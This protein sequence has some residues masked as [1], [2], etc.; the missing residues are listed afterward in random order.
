MFEGLRNLF[1]GSANGRGVLSRSGRDRASK[2]VAKS[3][4]H[5]VLVQDRAGLTP[6]EMASFKKEMVSVIEKYFVIDEGGFDISYKREVETTTLV[7]NSPVIVRRQ[8]APG[9]RVGARHQV[10]TAARDASKKEKLRREGMTAEGAVENTAD[11]I[12]EN[13]PG[14]AHGVTI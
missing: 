4:L 10:A 12:S 13:S 14:K 2:S 8:D 3:R 11:K 7:I 1:L 6:D 9:H 5:F